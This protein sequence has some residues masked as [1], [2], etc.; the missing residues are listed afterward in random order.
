MEF[1]N[2]F[3]YFKDPENNVDKFN[4]NSKNTSVTMF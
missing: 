1:I 3:K 2:A 4:N